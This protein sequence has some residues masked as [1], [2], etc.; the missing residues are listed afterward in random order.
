MHNF[1]T[2]VGVAIGLGFVVL[3]ARDIDPE[4]LGQTIQSTNPWWVLAAV[5]SVLAANVAK[6]FRWA[7]LFG[8]PGDRPPFRLLFYGVLLG[9]FAN[10]VLPARTGEVARAVL[11]NRAG[12]SASFAVGTLVTEKM[13]ETLAALALLLLTAAVVPLPDWARLAGLT[14]GVT[15]A[16]LLSAQWLLAR[17]RK[18]VAAIAEHWARLFRLPLAAHVPLRLQ[19]GIEGLSAFA[20]SGSLFALV[21]WTVV[22]WGAAVATNELVLR[23]L[24]LDLPVIASVW[25]LIVFQAG[26]ALPASIGR[27]GAFLYL[28]QLGLSVFDVD[29]TAAAGFG[30]ALFIIAYGSQVLL[31]IVALRLAGMS[32]R[33]LSPGEL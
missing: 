14:F 22:V 11:I 28:S 18:Q 23:S 7:L 26:I 9:Q 29:P 30:L 4:L 20:R 25:M 13:L 5:G 3:A 33:S 32:I 8:L 2:L 19:D 12:G 27:I 17:N 15:A 24:G 6:S 10:I 16:A 1:V 21:L 31:G